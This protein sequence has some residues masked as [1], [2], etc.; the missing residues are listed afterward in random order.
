MPDIG[1]LCSSTLPSPHQFN[2]NS[3][4]LQV[5][6]L[7]TPNFDHN[8]RPNT[9]EKPDCMSDGSDDGDGDVD[10]SG[11]KNRI[12]KVRVVNVSN[13][14]PV[15]QSLA[16]KGSDHCSKDHSGRTIS[17]SLPENR[18]LLSFLISA[19]RSV[20]CR[21]CSFVINPGDEVSCNV[22][23]CLGVYHMM[24]AKQKFGYSISKK[25][26]CHQHECFLCKQKFF[27]RCIRC[28]LASHDKCSPWP[29]KVIRLN[30][31]TGWVICWRHP[32][33][34]R[35]DKKL[36][37]AS[38]N[39]EELFCLLPLPYVEEDF[40]ID[41]MLKG[42]NNGKI[43]EMFHNLP[44]PSVDEEFWIDSNQK[45]NENFEVELPSY[46]NIRRNVY[47]VKK[48]RDG[49]F[50]DNGCTSC[51]STCEEDCVCRV[52][53]ISCSRDCHCAETCTNRPFRKEKQIKI[54]KTKHCGWGAEAAESINKG[55]FIIEYV[56]EVINDALCEQRLWDMKYKG[57]KNFYLCEIGKDFTIDA[58]FKGNSSR[59]LNH[60]CDPNCKLEKWQV[61]GETRVGVFAARAIEVGEPLTY[62]YRFVQFGPEEKCHC[63][64][65]NCQGYLGMKRRNG[66]PNLYWGSKRKRSVAACIAVLRVQEAETF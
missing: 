54:V 63:G 29:K 5:P 34:W 11:S 52:Q 35:Q 59:F 56:G 13:G 20:E 36:E 15:K 48:K 32:M 28:G 9:G 38:G 51:R 27:W 37:A 6:S 23:G 64:A 47:L 39:I 33:D 30:G 3:S 57:V 41:S 65:V 17:L 8:L 2:S 46:V 26:K 12:L 24:C 53:S 10:V 40:M 7:N 4:I 62:D 66:L 58:T 16:A 25:F 60:S 45:A 31:H 44:L 22:R 50:L 21:A 14:S 18:R 61:D 55:D 1:S 49:A 19:P 43:E 42:H